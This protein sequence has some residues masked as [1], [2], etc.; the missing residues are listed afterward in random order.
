[1][2]EHLPC[3]SSN[4]NLSSPDD[5]WLWAE[6]I[7]LNQQKFNPFLT[8]FEVTSI[9]ESI[10][11]QL[12]YQ[13]YQLVCKCSLDWVVQS[14]TSQRLWKVAATLLVGFAGFTRFKAIVTVLKHGQQRI[15]NIYDLQ[16]KLNCDW[17]FLTRC[18]RFLWWLPHRSEH[19]QALYEKGDPD[20]N[21]WSIN[22]P[23]I[24][25]FLRAWFCGPSYIQVPQVSRQLTPGSGCAMAAPMETLPTQAADV[26]VWPF[27]PKSVVQ[28][29]NEIFFQDLRGLLVEM[30][31]YLVSHNWVLQLFYLYNFFSV[32]NV[33]L[34][35]KAHQ[36]LERKPSEMTEDEWLGSEVSFGLWSMPFSMEGTWN[37]WSRFS[38]HWCESQIVSI[39]LSRDWFLF[40]ITDQCRNRS[41]QLWSTTSAFWVGVGSCTM[42][43][44]PHCFDVALWEL[45]KWFYSM[46]NAFV[47][48]KQIFDYFLDVQAVHHIQ[49]RVSMARFMFLL[50]G[51]CDKCAR[52]CFKPQFS[53]LRLYGEATRKP[54]VVCTAMGE[55]LRWAGVV[56]FYI[57]HYEI[58]KFRIVFEA[59]FLVYTAFD[60]W[61][62]SMVSTC[63]LCRLRLKTSTMTRRLE[64][65]MEW[66]LSISW[67]FSGPST[68]LP[69]NIPSRW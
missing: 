31:Q 3:L 30:V 62:C 17:H 27:G 9:P 63:W 26:S 52:I 12:K 42:Q 20:Q 66:Y 5:R 23:V 33:T 54:Q 21:A 39:H 10:S 60:S 29:E 34:E 28:A 38:T 69:W 68:I 18:Q 4:N 65:A 2:V 44:F 19:Q 32:E 41:S 14:L 15:K 48:V 51:Q 64:E 50:S 13:K 61:S 40:W 7:Y 56:F 67:S 8:Q 47:R 57:W 49:W 22:F 43:R 35:P 55:K 59:V 36:S 24:P 11:I 6:Y 58:L 25:I 37:T 1:M 45:R 46:Q 53:G 16:S